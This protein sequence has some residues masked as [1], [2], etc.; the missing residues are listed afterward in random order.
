MRTIS[1]RRLV[2]ELLPPWNWPIPFAIFAVGAG[3]MPPYL[4]P[5]VNS[6]CASGLKSAAGIVLFVNAMFFVLSGPQLA[7][8][9]QFSFV[10]ESVQPLSVWPAP[11]NAVC[12]EDETW[13][14]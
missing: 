1:S 12:M 9:T 11:V 10:T 4:P 3:K 7:P 13:Q 2:G 5:A 6:D 14:M 8:V